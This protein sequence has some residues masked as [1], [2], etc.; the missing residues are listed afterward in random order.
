MEIKEYGTVNPFDGS[1]HEEMLAKLNKG[2]DLMADE[3]YMSQNPKYAELRRNGS[4]PK[5]INLSAESLLNF[6]EK[7][8]NR[9]KW[10]STNI[11]TPNDD[12]NVLIRFKGV[13]YLAHYFEWFYS[14]NGMKVINTHIDYWMEIPEPPQITK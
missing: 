2:Y 7:Y 4:M 11:Y 9:Q 3:Y 6:A 12:T 8:D 14:F 10:L 1:L 13:I 5:N